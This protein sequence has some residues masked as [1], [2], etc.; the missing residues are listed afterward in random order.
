MFLKD[1]P[2]CWEKVD[3]EAENV[4]SKENSW[5]PNVVII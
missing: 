1:H 5:E 3:H 2:D 4:A